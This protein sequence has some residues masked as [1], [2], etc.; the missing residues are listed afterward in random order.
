VQRIISGPK[1]DG[2]EDGEKYEDT[3]TRLI[4]CTLHQT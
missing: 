3:K 1:T 4:I 2:K